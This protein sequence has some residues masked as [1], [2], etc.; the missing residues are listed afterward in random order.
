MKT[1]RMT[2][3]PAR[4]FRTWPILILF[5]AGCG[6]DAVTTPT[7]TTT[8]TATATVTATPSSATVSVT[9]SGESAYK[10]TGSFTVA[11]SNTN[12][13]PITIRSITADLQQASGGIVITPITGT[14]EAF[15]F[16]VRAPFNRIDVNSNMTIPFT[17]HYALPNGGREA[18]VSLSFSVVT[19]TGAS[20]S[21]TASVNFQ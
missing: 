18:L 10:W 7:D 9:P 3:S 16:D 13:S 1:N 2:F 4:L 20:G 19:D 17:F 5:A 15:R 6:K 21:V 12:A 14:D 8:T 11:I